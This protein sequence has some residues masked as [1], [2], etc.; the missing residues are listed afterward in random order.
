[1]ISKGQQKVVIITT[2]YL[3][4]CWETINFVLEW[5]RG[6]KK[7]TRDEQKSDQAMSNFKISPIPFEVQTGLATNLPVEYNITDSNYIKIL[8][9]YYK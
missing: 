1:M 2:S 6:R 9:Y 8:P 5:P 4:L 7:A 3:I